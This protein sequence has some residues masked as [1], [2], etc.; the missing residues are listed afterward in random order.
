M[1]KGA[2]TRAF[3][4]LAAARRAARLSLTCRVCL[5]G[6]AVRP[7]GG[8]SLTPGARPA[9]IP[10]SHGKGTPMDVNAIIPPPPVVYLEFDGQVLI[11][12]TRQLRWITTLY[13]NLAALFDERP[14]IFVAGDLLWYPVEGQPEVRTAP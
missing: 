13:G 8:P 1:S 10:C 3:P 4:G 9:S 5:A 6:I 12:N 7:G 14:D 2:R 11:D